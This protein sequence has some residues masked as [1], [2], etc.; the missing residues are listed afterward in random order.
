MN[1]QEV[2]IENDKDQDYFWNRLREVVCEKIVT[3][4]DYF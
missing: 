1:Q 3:E 2:V 4:K